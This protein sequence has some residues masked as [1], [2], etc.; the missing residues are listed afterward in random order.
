WF[1][2]VAHTIGWTRLLI[3][4]TNLMHGILWGI[5]HYLFG[6]N[7]GLCIILLTLLVRA[8]MFPL[9]RKQTL[10][11]QR[12]Q[13]KMAKLKP[14]IEK[15]KEKH[16][17][18]QQA[19]RQAQTELMLK[20][21]L[22]N[23]LGSCWIM[24]LQMPIF[25]GLYFCL[26]ESI[27][28]RLASFAWVE[29]LAAP[30]MLIYWSQSI[31]L[32]SSPSNY[33]GSLLS[34]LYLGPFFNLLPIIAVGFMIVQQSMMMP[35][36]TDEQ[37]A[38]QQKM[39]KYMTVFFGL[40]FYKVA[41]GLCIYFI[42][43]SAWGF[44]ERKLLP[45]KQPGGPDRPDQPRGR[46]SQWML[47]RMQAVRDGSASAGSTSPPS[48]NG[49]TQNPNIGKR[50]PKKPQRKPAPVTNSNGMLHRLRAWWQQVLKEARKK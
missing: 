41:A 14:E 42:V 21:G 25:M 9:S 35:P 15:L 17:G 48:S 39:M 40:M 24:L 34:I 26:Q 13:D 43:S 7:Y 49:P 29:N 31:P 46:F 32:I 4:C 33:S 44:C 27:H 50:N 2:D 37:A 18:D 20:N 28:F 6:L 45:K 8:A 10:A 22:I 38:A 23:P 19:F 11:A 36:P 30:D 3:W 12:M 1:G 47:E 5:H 16:K